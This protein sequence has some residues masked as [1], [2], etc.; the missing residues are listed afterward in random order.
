MQSTQTTPVTGP[1][2]HTE[3]TATPQHTAYGARRYR[4]PSDPSRLSE[5]TSAVKASLPPQ[6]AWGSC[7]HT[8]IT[9]THECV[10]C[11]HCARPALSRQSQPCD[12]GSRAGTSPR[13][14]PHKHVRVSDSLQP[15]PASDSSPRA[16]G[17]TQFSNQN[18]HRPPGG[19]Q[20]PLATPQ[21]WR[22]PFPPSRCSTQ[23]RAPGHT[24]AGPP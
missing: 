19:A 11:D 22:S 7:W 18:L 12:P 17:A 23:S 6:A 3:N 13:Q 24:E 14:I 5:D 21:V 2:G 10:C 16:P 8:S 1:A 4:A 9:A 15:S 20:S